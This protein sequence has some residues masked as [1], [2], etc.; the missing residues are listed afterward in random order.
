[1]AFVKIW[2]HFVWTT[3]KRHP[4]IQK[5]VK[6][7]LINHIRENAI[8]KDIYVD[9]MDGDKEHL[10]ILISLS[11]SQSVADVAR[12]LKDESS[13]W[14]NNSDLVQGQFEWQDEYFAVSVSESVVP[15]VRNYINRQE[16]HHRVK[17][18]SEEYDEFMRKYGFHK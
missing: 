14:V 16:E 7:K 1:M 17:P 13:H 4:F 2:V 5:I 15:K 8:S 9:S 12:L 10:H 11:S 18:F 3:K 6:E